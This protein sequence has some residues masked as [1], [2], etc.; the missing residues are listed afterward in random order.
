MN[1]LELT[2]TLLDGARFATGTA[3][4]WLIQSTLLIACGLAVGNLFRQRGSAVQS[5]IYRTTLLATLLCPLATTALSLLGVTGWSLTMPAA[6]SVA[7]LPTEVKYSPQVASLPNSSNSVPANRAPDPQAL[8][9]ACSF[10]AAGD[11]EKSREGAPA[12]VAASAPRPA[13][14]AATS[15]AKSPGPLSPS[16]FELQGFAIEASL[17]AALWTVVSIGLLLRIGLSWLQLHRLRGGAQIADAKT[18]NTCH[19]LAATLGVFPPDVMRTPYLPSPCLAGLR[20]P[21]VLLPEADLNLPIR[22]VL[23]HELAHL[24]RQD[25]FWNLVRQAATA[26]LFFQPLM[27]KLSRRL[28]TTAEEVCDDYVVQFGGDRREYAH[29]LVDIATLSVVPLSSAGVGIVSIRSM[30]GSRVARIL[31]TSRSL[32]T[33]IGNFALALVLVAGLGATLLV[34]FVGLNSA[35]HAAAATENAKT[36]DKPAKTSS[37]SGQGNSESEAA[38]ADDLVTVRGR[39][40]DPT[41]KPVAGA[42]VDVLRWYWNLGTPE[43]LAVT[44][45]D[46]NGR[47]SVA[48]RKSQYFESS[49]RPGQWREATIAA[50]G[51][52]FGVGWVTYD[53]IAPGKEATIKLAV[54][55]APIEGRILDL[56]GKPV[57][58]ATIKVDYLNTPKGGDLSEW[59][60]AVREG[61]SIPAAARLFSDSAPLVSAGRWTGIKTDGDGRFRLTG[62]GRERQLNIVVEGPTIV[63][64]ELSVVTRDMPPLW[65]LT[66]DFPGALQRTNFGAKF[67]YTAALSRP[68]E[69]VIRDAKTGKPLAGAEVWSSRFAGETLHGV[70]T[71]KTKSDADGHYVLN[72]MPKGKGNEVFVVPTDL[73]YFT[74]VFEIPDPDGID[75]VPFDIRLHRGVWV[76]GKVI[77]ERT[78]RGVPA[79]VHYIVRP[80]NPLA[81]LPEFEYGAHEMHVQDRFRTKPDGSYRVVA[82][83][84]RGIIGV[85]TVDGAYPSGQ[86]LAT[87][88]GIINRDA[89]NKYD[90]VFAPSKKGSTAYKEVETKVDDDS[91]ACDFALSHGKE[92]TVRAV[93]ANGALVADCSVTGCAAVDQLAE[94]KSSGEFTVTAMGDG[95]ERTLLIHQQARHIGKG[96][97]IKAADCAKGP[98]EVRLEPCG[99][100]TGQL[101][102]GD[103]PAQGVNLRI[104]VSGDGDYGKQLNATTTDADGRF[105]YDGFLPGLAYDIIGEGPKVEFVSVTE[106]L[107]LKPGETVDIGTIDIKSKERPEMKRTPAADEMKKSADTESTDVKQGAQALSPAKESAPASGL[108]KPANIAATLRTAQ[109]VST[110][111]KAI[112]GAKVYLIEWSSRGEQPAPRLMATSNGK[113]LVEFSLPEVNRNTVEATERMKSQQIVVVANGYGMAYLTPGDLQ[114]L[115]GLGAVANLIAGGSSAATIGLSKEVPLKGRIMT[116]DGRRVAN[117]RISIRRISNDKLGVEESWRRD[118]AARG[119]EKSEI[120]WRV[121]LDA[122]ANLFFPPQLSS[123]APTA[124]TGDDGWFEL[125]GVSGDRILQLLVEGDG[126]ESALIYA[127]TSAGETLTLKPTPGYGNEPDKIYGMGFTHILGYSKPVEGRVVDIDTQQPMAGAIVRAFEVHGV[128]MYSSRDRQHFVAVTDSDGHFRITGLP[129]GDDNSLVAFTT[130]DEPYVPSGANMNTDVPEATAHQDFQ[131]KRGVWAEGRAYDATTNKPLTGQVEYFVSRNPELEKAI[132]GLRHAYMDESYYTDADG[133]FRVPVVAASGILAFRYA[134]SDGGNL[135]SYTRGMGK[136]QITGAKQIDNFSMFETLPTYLMPDNYSAVAEIAPKPGDKVVEVNFALSN[137][138]PI[139][140]HVVDDEGHH[141]AS[142]LQFYG[143]TEM[144]GWDAAEGD[145]CQAKSLRPNEKRDLFFYLRARNLVGVTTVEAQ[146]KDPVTVKLTTGG[147]IRGR[148]VN[149]DGEPVGDVTLSPNIREAN[150]ASWPPSPDLYFNPGRL[151]VG[152]DGRFAIEGL[153]TGKKYPASVLAERKLNGNMSL[154]TIGTVFEDVTVEAGKT[155]DLGDVVVADKKMETKKSEQDTKSSTPAAKTSA[156]D[157]EHADDKHAEIRGRVLGPNGKPDAGAQIAVIATS[158]RV[159]RGGD[160]DSGDV[161]IA[162]TTSNAAGE[163]ELAIHGLSSK[164]HRSAAIVASAEG[165]GIAWQSLDPDARDVAAEF[166]LKP[167]ETIRGRLTDIEGKP[168][169][170]VRMSINNVAPKVEGGLFTNGLGF[171]GK[172]SPAAWPTIMA[173][174]DAG[175]FEIHDIAASYGVLITIAGD[176]RIAPQTVALNTGISDRRDERDGTYRPQVVKNLQPGE[177]AVIPLAPSQVFE[178]EVTYA[179]TGKPAP[180]ARLTIWSSQQKYGS[181]MSLAGTADAAGHY[182]ISAY[183]GIRFGLTAY[184][185]DGVEYLTR[186]L[187]PV[188]WEG[189]S[190][191][192]QVSVQL[193][194]GVMVHG[195][196]VDAASGAAVPG[197]T[198]Q[199]IPEAANNPNAKEDILTGWEGIQVANDNGEFQIVVLPG[200]GRLLFQGAKADFILRE[201]SKEELLRGRPGG[202]RVY[203]HAIERIAPQPDSDPLEMAVKLERGATVDGTLVD[204]KGRPADAILIF[205]LNISPREL[206]WRGDAS[207]A[208]HAGRFTLAGL[209]PHETYKVYFLDAKHRTGATAVISADD[210]SPRITLTPCAKAKAR[211]VNDKNH[212]VSGFRPSIQMVV[213]PGTDPYDFAAARSGDPAADADY[214]TNIDRTNYPFNS[215]PTDADGQFTFPALISGATYRIPLQDK[216]G[217]RNTREFTVDGPDEIDLGDLVVNGND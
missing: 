88:T 46:E 190:A 141:I 13:L 180:N 8:D 60:K 161:V 20:R 183:P 16:L 99:T 150:S 214:V 74:A 211:F 187:P 167:E 136:E 148:L 87:I 39:V 120:D 166:D 70:T 69:G 58:G 67:D 145:N 215:T 90:G 6:Y 78:K 89:Y 84:G 216:D 55:D 146:T 129:T 27:W 65:Q 114:P 51:E 138:K 7:V 115:S 102:N 11:L 147:G 48:Y 205:R 86:G 29:R 54:D 177:E 105:R 85:K 109:V 149:S 121:R 152:K 201:T 75:P 181:M 33:R 30:L 179:D 210:K 126:V 108:N 34:G 57:A 168:V 98:I 83:P 164:S 158:S 103:D 140:V 128:R 79:A 197:A 154:M 97:R 12:T 132:P 47:F 107:D 61:Q 96:L 63:T 35:P 40:V 73:P 142:G 157:D 53:K 91:T 41:G 82:L 77:D 21:A 127:R 171:E 195:K 5:A 155:I 178:G 160:F 15:N 56:E 143:Q 198:V 44:K 139:T 163:Y 113:G 172:Q 81:N 162:E 112:A 111:G 204:D 32:S 45:A 50:F 185:P 31:D 94:R 182:Q 62:I 68:I 159:G 10:V 173:S 59:L 95:E 169:A 212:P 64:Q 134:S 209:A 200:P 66:F 199:Y 110:E 43:P 17:V 26:L 1:W 116:I 192:K 42:D 23:V 188:D 9:S 153:I 174:D 189:G 14:N 71:I 80:D 133:R 130:G 117:A 213:T 122:I 28:A 25:C 100:V 203:A 93:D 176:D 3:A 118:L 52:G 72:G 207:V 170:G 208:V 38:D 144:S 123:A 2:T 125:R 156:T 119:R 206:S 76:S 18:V 36:E 186:Q 151:P 92:V 217:A 19:Q 137:G 135:G 196:V 4:N 22:D 165:A 24:L 131:L 202:Q 37:G 104:D 49:G 101:V 191:H 193:P 175:K 194:R 124:K 184:P 106:K